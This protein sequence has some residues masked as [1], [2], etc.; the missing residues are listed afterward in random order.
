MTLT[1]RFFFLVKNTMQKSYIWDGGRVH[2]PKTGVQL[3]IKSVLS[4]K[5]I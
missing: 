4:Q 2:F 5:I 1:G 3:F